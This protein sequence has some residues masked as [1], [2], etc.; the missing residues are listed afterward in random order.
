MIRYGLAVSGRIVRTTSGFK[1]TSLLSILRS[2]KYMQISFFGPSYSTHVSITLSMALLA[3]RYQTDGE[4][5]SVLFFT[6]EGDL[7][8]APFMVDHPHV[9]NSPDGLPQF[10]LQ[11]NN[12]LLLLMN[13]IVLCH[14]RHLG[15]LFSF[16][17]LL[18][19]ISNPLVTAAVSTLILSASAHATSF[20]NF[21]FSAGAASLSLL[22]LPLYFDSKVLNFCLM[23]ALLSSCPR[24][25]ALCCCWA[26]S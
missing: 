14:Q 20:F 5:F 16:P 8:L 25:S 9:S 22:I 7:G 3:I 6:F 4:Q 19:S 17:H 24:N 21:S 1:M 15:I 2:E 12:L 10:F 18:F 26:S 11:G 13:L 23:A